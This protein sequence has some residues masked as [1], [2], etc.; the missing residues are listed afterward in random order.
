MMLICGQLYVDAKLTA[1]LEPSIVLICA[2]YD[3]V[4]TYLNCEV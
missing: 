4:R 3:M 2:T 1:T